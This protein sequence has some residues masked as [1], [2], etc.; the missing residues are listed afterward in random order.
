MEQE[1]PSTEFTE[2]S[3]GAGEAAEGEGTIA[4][5]GEGEDT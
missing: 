2:S 1:S 3:A 5:R 4:G